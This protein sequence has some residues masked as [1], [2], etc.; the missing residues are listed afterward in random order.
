MSKD[1]Y[2]RVHRKTAESIVLQSGTAPRTLQRFLESIK[3]DE[4]K[5]RDQCQQIVAGDHAHPEAIGCVDESG[6]TKSGKETV[7]VH[8]HFYVTQLSHLFCGRMRQAYD[9][10]TDEQRISVEQ[11]CSAMDVWFDTAAFPLPRLAASVSR[12]N[13]TSSNTINAATSRLGSRTR[14]P[15]SNDWPHW[16]STLRESNLVSSTQDNDDIGR[17]AST[18]YD[19]K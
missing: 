9:D 1:N 4:E 7:G 8:R 3:W 13:S 10:A 2:P 18:T 12:K 6:T 19:K 16:A 14:K 5:L 11:V 15:E 17:S